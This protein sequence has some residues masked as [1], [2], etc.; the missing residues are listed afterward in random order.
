MGPMSGG[1]TDTDLDCTEAVILAPYFLPKTGAIYGRPSKKG[2]H[3]LYITDDPDERAWIQWRDD[4][5]KVLLELRMG[6]GGKGAQSVLPGSVHTSGELYEWDANGQPAQYSCAELK[7]GCVKLAAASLLMRHW[8]SL[9]ALHDTALGVG[10]FLA[11]A[12]WTPDEV[13][14]FVKVICSELHDVHDT[15]KHAKTARD[16]AVAHAKGENVRGLP[17]MIGCFG[18]QVAIAVAKI[19]GYAGEREGLLEEMNSEY[20]VVQF[21]GKVRILNFEEV[22]RKH[23]GGK[24]IH[25]VF[26]G[27]DDF[28]LL[29]NNQKVQVGDDAIGLATWWLN[30]KSR[31][32]YKG[33]VFRPGEPSEVGGRLNLWRGWAIEPRKGDWLLMRRHIKEVLAAGD[34][35]SDEYIIKWTAWALQNPGLM[36]EV[37]LVFKGGKGVG[38]GAFVKALLR[39]FGQHGLQVGSMKMLTGNF[40]AHLMDCS[41]LYADE[42]YWPGDKSA[43]GMLKLIITE[44][45]LPIE[46][47]TFD[48]ISADNALHLIMAGNDDW[49][50]PAS[51]DERRFAAFEVSDKY[52]GD[53]DYF[54]ALF[55]QTLDEGG[56]AAMMFDLLELDLNGW[57]PR[58]NVPQTALLQDQKRLSLPAGDQWWLHLLEEGSLPGAIEENPRR[59]PS[60]VLFAE[61]KKLIPGLKYSS[62]HILARFLRKR[63]CIDCRVGGGKTRS[64]EFP[65]LAEARAAWD[66]AIGDN[67]S[68]WS[69][70]ADWQVEE[71]GVYSSRIFKVVG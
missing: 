32:Q 4:E 7:A 40:N 9:G 14:Y 46:K 68:H 22:P 58:Y 65:P 66:A 44:E 6:G 12:G 59:A 51:M 23:G 16:S 26:Y 25:A 48:V 34:E 8:P 45:Q 2:S 21:G 38:K 69:D 36:A 70:Q 56:V 20:C 19:I 60:A 49:V 35:A 63:G 62:P 17:W 43:E 37:A 18:E 67:N 33:V 47:K 24:R 31:R 52:Q 30:H 13:G 57:H 50:A 39:I 61:A 3:R 53:T 1:L 5:Q 15:D 10:G 55:K 27:S 71:P 42:A 64:W 29:L 28:R 11:R 54:K 41:L